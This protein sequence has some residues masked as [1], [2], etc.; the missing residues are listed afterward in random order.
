MKKSEA[1]N[2]LLR[3]RPVIMIL[4]SF[5]IC[6]LSFVG[7]ARMGTPD[8]GWYDDDPPRILGSAPADKA[9]GVKSKKVTIFF[10]EFIIFFFDFFLFLRRMSPSHR[11]SWRCLRLPPRVRR[12]WCS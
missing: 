9:T 3:Q 2:R 10:D 7:C 12:L 8:G 6:H 1:I 5:I 11:L 4:L